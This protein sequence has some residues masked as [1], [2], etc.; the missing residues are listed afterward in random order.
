VNFRPTMRQLETLAEMDMARA[1]V[2]AMAE[3]V[4]LERG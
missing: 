3:A 4:G 1:P 2:A